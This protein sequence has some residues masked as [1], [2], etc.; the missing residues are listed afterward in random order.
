[1]NGQ[2]LPS[3]FVNQSADTSL[4]DRPGSPSSK[5]GM[6]ALPAVAVPSNLKPLH[7]PLF[8]AHFDSFFSSNARHSF[9]VKPRIHRG[10]SMLRCA[11]IRRA[12]ALRSA[13]APPCECVGS[14]GSIG[15]SDSNSTSRVPASAL[16]AAAT[17]PKPS[18][19][20]I[21]TAVGLQTGSPLFCVYLFENVNLHGLIGHQP[22]EPRVLFFQRP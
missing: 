19:T 14:P 21:F 16:Q 22:L 2:A 4:S 18:S 17:F 7:P 10:V 3:V 12:D 1:M 9:H 13:P 8:L 6:L 5:H 11:D 15:R 20:L